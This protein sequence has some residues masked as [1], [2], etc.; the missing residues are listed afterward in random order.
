M[1]DECNKGDEMRA[2]VRKMIEALKE[3]FDETTLLSIV[4]VFAVGGGHALMRFMS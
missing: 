3:K 1:H 2:H 4:F